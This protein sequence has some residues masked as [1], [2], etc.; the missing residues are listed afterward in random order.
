MVLVDDGST[1]NTREIIK[2]FNEPRIKYIK[3]KHDF[4]DSRNKMFK[5]ASGKY[6]TILDSGDTY[7]NIDRL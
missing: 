2:S 6:I 1:D 4:I 7:D 3:N 5:Y